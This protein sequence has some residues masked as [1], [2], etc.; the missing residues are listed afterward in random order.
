MN[1][2]QLE[3][4]IAVAETG[5]FS[6]GA[7]LICLT[8]STVS[9]HVAALEAAVGSALL[10]RT[11]R[12]VLL[13]KGGELFIQH[14]RRILAERDALLQA[15]AAFRG[16]EDARLNIGASNIPANYL[17]PTLLVEMQQKYPGISLAMITGDSLDMLQRLESAEIELALV[18]SRFDQRGVDFLP[19]LSDPLVLI[20][21]PNHR[22]VR[23]GELSLEELVTEPLVVRENGS[24]SGRALESALRQAGQ[25]PATLKIAARLG[26]NEAV[27]LAVAG[28]FGCAFVSGLSVRQHLQRGE[29][30]QI[31]VAGLTVDRKIWLARSQTRTLSPAAQVFSEFLMLNCTA[32]EPGRKPLA[33]R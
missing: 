11:G 15:M 30:C 24:G 9:Q 29:L 17:I 18:G 6:R 21:A 31:E 22:W 8:Q 16:L 7:E 25:D 33:E 26:S 23:Q 27:L 14:A 3:L 20:V 12:G 5:S 1:F 10:D 28:G 4:F 32:A 19:L 13:T 2:R